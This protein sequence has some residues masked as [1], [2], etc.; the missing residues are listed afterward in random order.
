MA[1]PG[2]PDDEAE[3]GE[4]ASTYGLGQRHDTWRGRRAV[5]HGGSWAGYRAQLFRLPAERLGVAIL[6]NAA[7]VGDLGVKAR[8]IAAAALGEP[9]DEPERSFLVRGASILDGTGARA[10][11]GD[12]S[13]G[14][15]RCRARRSSRRADGRS[16][17]ASS[18]LTATPTTRSAS[19]RAPSP[20]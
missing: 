5:S 3:A 20:R 1:L 13:A 15:L 16:R 10:R 17:P 7:E 6:C 18:T 2:L 4:P 19:T 14:C 11:R 8:R 12:V 9:L